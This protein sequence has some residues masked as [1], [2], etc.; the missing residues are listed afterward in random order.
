PSD[1]GSSESKELDSDGGASEKK[2]VVLKNVFSP[3][4]LRTPDTPLLSTPEVSNEIR[5]LTTIQLRKRLEKVGISPGP[6]L[7]DKRKYFEK[8]LALIEKQETEVY[9]GRVYSSAL[10]KFLRAIGRGEQPRTGLTF[11]DVIRNEFCIGQVITREKNEVSSFCYV[12]IDPSMIKDQ[13]NCTF[14]EFLEAVF[15]IGK[16]KRSRPL[17]HLVDAAKVKKTTSE[18]KENLKGEKPI[19]KK[20]KKI[21]DLWT[22]GHGIISLSIFQNIHPN[23]AYIREAAMID[24]FGL[25][26]L[27]NLKSGE[28]S[29]NSKCWKL[30]EKTEFGVFCLHSAWKIFL[31]ERCR[32]VFEADVSDAL[33]TMETDYRKKDD[34]K[35]IKREDLDEERPLNKRRKHSRDEED[36]RKKSREED[37][38]YRSRD[39]ED[40]YRYRSRDEENYRY[41]RTHSRE[42]N[43][44]KRSRD[45]EEYVSRHRRDSGRHKD[46]YDGRSKRTQEDDSSDDEIYNKLREIL[47]SRIPA[48]REVSPDFDSSEMMM[49]NTLPCFDRIRDFE[50]IELRKKFFEDAQI[51]DEIACKVLKMTPKELELKPECTM[52]RYRRCLYRI[53]FPPTTVVPIC[54]M[55]L[56]ACARGDIISARIVQID[57]D[58]LKVF[59]TVNNYGIPLKEEQLPA[60][61]RKLPE[62]SEDDPNLEHLIGLGPLKTKFSL[63]PELVNK[64]LENPRKGPE[65][66]KLKAAEQE[67]AKFVEEGADF[68]KKSNNFEGIK[69]F[70]KALEIV[71]NFVAALIGRAAAF[72]NEKNFDEAL[73]DLKFVREIDP[74]DE[75]ARSYLSTVLMVSGQEMEEEGKLEAAAERYRE[76]LEVSDDNRARILMGSISLD[77][78]LCIHSMSQIVDIVIQSLLFQRGIIQEP[79]HQMRRLEPNNRNLLKYQSICDCLRFVFKACNTRILR[80]LVVVLGPTPYMA[81][82]IYSIPI[83]FCEEHTGSID[84]GCGD[85]C[86][87]LSSSESR[88]VF[89]NIQQILGSIEKPIKANSKLFV[90][91][92]VSEPLLN[93]G[94]SEDIEEDDGFEIPDEELIQRR[95]VVKNEIKVEKCRVFVDESEEREVEE[96]GN[97]NEEIEKERNENNLWLRL[98]PFVVCHL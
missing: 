58:N 56:M 81:Q 31:N 65:A 35:N 16:G 13:F 91:V 43:H 60:Y 17:Q 64:D 6:L 69:S 57:L 49:W 90:F 30:K 12:L 63:L 18:K 23:E 79:I 28:Y 78:C 51:G 74:D 22:K 96:E 4:I 50:G 33:K 44:R 94:D 62:I 47:K 71:P 93:S 1:D 75:T 52:T 95:H 36:Y 77:R 37:Y 38:R 11:E 55:E 29:G 21:C 46:D 10:E 98:N 82:E 40:D 86:G 26:N 85:T 73:K 39:E 2:E 89:M 87:S 8:K 80:E 68:V 42:D 70:G 76:A 7:E 83:K 24:A 72:A 32:P 41:R 53:P 19:S 15:Y 67:A 25:K 48:R 20:L 61:Y 59:L 84:T 14:K 9:G 27:T 3:R 45:E 88:S 92:R 34:K 66:L 97:E 5:G 54:E